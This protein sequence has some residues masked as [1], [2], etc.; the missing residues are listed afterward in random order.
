MTE[1]VIAVF[2]FAI[3]IALGAGMVFL[4]KDD[5]DQRRTIRA[6]T[7]RIGLSLA[8]IAMLVLGYYL[9]LIQPHGVQP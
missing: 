7:W 8:L 1:A 2:L 4:V 9:G 5:G 6:L 3:V